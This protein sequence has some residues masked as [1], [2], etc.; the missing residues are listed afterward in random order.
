MCKKLILLMALCAPVSA[1]A[2]T[3]TATY[4]VQP[5]PHYGGKIYTV[6]ITLNT[7]VVGDLQWGTTC[8]QQFLVSF[9][10]TYTA[11][12]LG[13]QTTASQDFASTVVSQPVTM[14][15][16]AAYS[17]FSNGT[18][19]FPIGSY[20]VQFAPSQLTINV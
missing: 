11:Y 6:G 5:Q 12:F 7:P 10:Q 14:T 20:D 17:Q 2:Q 3:Y 19:P 1:L 4:S 8:P 15:C 13:G 18:G 16:T 9:Y